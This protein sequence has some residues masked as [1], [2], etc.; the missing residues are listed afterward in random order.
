MT[1]PPKATGG[2]IGTI[3]MVIVGLMLLYYFFD[4][5]I[6]E[7]GETEKGKETI[8]YGGRLLEAIVVYIKDLIESIRSR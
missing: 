1:L 8:F 3:V 7:I 2:F 5:S 4:W 6:F